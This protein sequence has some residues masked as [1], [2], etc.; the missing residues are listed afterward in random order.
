M[1][2]ITTADGERLEV[3][4]D[5]QAD[6]GPKPG[7]KPTQEV[8]ELLKSPSIFMQY[9]ISFENGMRSSCPPGFICPRCRQRLTEVRAE[10]S[11]VIEPVADVKAV[12]VC[13][14][15][16]LLLPFRFRIRDSGIIECLYNGKWARRSLYVSD[17]SLLG[18][19]K[20]WLGQG[21]DDED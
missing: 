12:G 11:R 2:T 8:L 15:C 3:M 7:Y 19:L 5:D 9:P 6:I 21:N 13:R 17:R 20:A 16:K 10:I 4:V 14:D 1:R 18:R